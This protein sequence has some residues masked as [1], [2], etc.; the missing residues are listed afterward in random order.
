M[1]ARRQHTYAICFSGGYT[2][3]HAP[4]HECSYAYVSAVGVLVCRRCVGILRQPFVMESSQSGPGISATVGAAAVSSSSLTPAAWRAA[5][6]SSRRASMSASVRRRTSVASRRRRRRRLCSRTSTRSVGLAAGCLSVF[7]APSS[8]AS[9]RA[10]WCGGVSSRRRRRCRPA[11]RLDGA[12]G[13]RRSRCLHPPSTCW[14]TP[15]DEQGRHGLVLQ[16]VLQ[17]LG[18]HLMPAWCGR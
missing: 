3:V 15:E 14:C 11:A 1:E 18:L 5:P 6:A 2:Y 8:S 13:C 4:V 7:V 17:F 9:S 12:A 10:R 16:L